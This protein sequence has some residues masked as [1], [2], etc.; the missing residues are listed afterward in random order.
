MH[1]APALVGTPDPGLVLRRRA[2]R[3][4]SRSRTPAPCP[5]CGS[6]SLTPGRGRARHLVL[7]LALAVLARSA[8]PR[9]R[10]DLKRF[11]PTSVL[12]TGAR[13]H[14]LLGR[15]HDHGRATSS[16]ARSPVPRTST[17]TASCATSRA[18]RCRSRSGNSPDPIEHDRP[19][20]RRRPALHDGAAHAP[21]AGHPASRTKKVEIGRNFANKLWNAARLVQPHLATAT[22]PTR[23]GA[24]PA[25]TD[26]D[27]WILIA[28]AT[29][30]PLG[31]AQSQDLPLQRR[32]QG[33]LR[34]HVARAL[35]LVPRDG[36]AAALRGDA[37]ADAAAVRYTIHQV[38][39]TVL[40]RCSIRSCRSS[41]RRSGRRS[42]G[43]RGT[44][45]SPDGR[46]RR[47]AP[48]IRRPRGEDRAPEGSRVATVRNLRSEM[49]IAP[50]R[51]AAILIRAK[52]TTPMSLRRA[53]GPDL[54]ARPG[55]SLEW[56][57]RSRSP[58][59]PP[60]PWSAITRSSSRSR[61]SS[62]STWS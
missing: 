59:S 23:S 36:Q 35:R 17:S 25:L 55:E 11:Y 41:P 53:A 56:G 38:F 39:S 9:R 19:V 46:R 50:A 43:R 8:G 13:H 1:L 62:T 10:E 12:V 26:A 22:S 37:D 33:A 54:A 21:R 57:R 61:V 31:D 14:L 42:R 51:K 45:A 15:A 3:C 44:S 30:V 48:R 58:T 16:W 7:V 60:R 32:G 24:R 49:N 34:L 20:R 40:L 52:G 18:G 4:S 6:T 2:A 47:G 5:K 28:L 27:R 29:R